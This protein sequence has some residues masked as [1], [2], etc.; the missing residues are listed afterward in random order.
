M[1]NPVSSELQAFES[2]DVCEMHILRDF[3]RDRRKW[4]TLEHWIDG[5]GVVV[6]ELQDGV[7]NVCLHLNALAGAKLMREHPR[8]VFDELFAW[9]SD[10]IM[11][12]RRRL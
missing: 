5:G 8:C 1:R 11:G 7:E 10:Y 12:K 3:M 2:P 9:R 6:H 4:R